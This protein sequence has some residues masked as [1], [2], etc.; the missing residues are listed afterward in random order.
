MTTK[1]KKNSLEF[2]H[3][4]ELYLINDTNINTCL[5]IIVLHIFKA[6]WWFTMV[7]EEPMKKELFLLALVLNVNLHQY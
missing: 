2:F 3:L 4:G 1:K 6:E 5:E 7:W